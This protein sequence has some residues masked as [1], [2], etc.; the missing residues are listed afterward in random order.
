MNYAQTIALRYR[1]EGRLGVGG[2]ST[3]YKAFD[4]TLERQVLDVVWR[5]GRASVRDVLTAVDHSVAYTTAMTVMDR[6]F[7]NNAKGIGGQFGG[8]AARNSEKPGSSG[9]GP[10]SGLV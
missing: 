6:L 7:K 4:R 1:I 5:L 2:M 3:V 10:G 9:E 8:Q